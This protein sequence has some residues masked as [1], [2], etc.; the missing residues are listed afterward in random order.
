[1]L[2]TSD[3]NHA[4]LR[5]NYYKAIRELIAVLQYFV[6]ISVLTKDWIWFEPVSSKINYD[7]MSL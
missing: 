6:L 3:I 5:R 2:R 7:I 1:M 4:Y